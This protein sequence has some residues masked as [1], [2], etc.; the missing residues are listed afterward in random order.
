MINNLFRRLPASGKGFTLIEMLVA[1]LL[2]TMAIAGP[3]TLSSKGV[4]VALIAKDQTIAFYLAQDAVE[5]VRYARDTNSLG[6]GAWLTGVGA[7]NGINLSPCISAAGTTYCYFNTLGAGDAP[8]VPTACAQ[9]FCTDQPLYYNP[10]GKYYTYS[11]VTGNT[12]TIFTR[13]VAIT[14][15]VNSVATEAVLAVT[16]RWSDVAGVTRSIT[17]TESLFDW[18]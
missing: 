15:P 2:L 8:L 17:V 16:V 9:A 5:Y 10:S 3:L 13:A 4:V 1:V 11:Q 12:R 7:A 6:N 14:N 18:Q